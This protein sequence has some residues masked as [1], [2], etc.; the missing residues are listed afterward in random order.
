MKPWIPCA[1][2]LAVI[3]AATTVHPLVAPAPVEGFNWE[4]MT[5][6]GGF[7]LVPDA[8][9]FRISER[10][11]KL[12]YFVTK[13]PITAQGFDTGITINVIRALPRT[14]GVSPSAFA[15][16]I[17]MQIENAEAV[18][19]SWN[20]PG[21]VLVEHGVEWID[22]SQDVWVRN[23]YRLLAND[24]TGTLYQVSF[25]TPEDDRSETWPTAMSVL[26]RILFDGSI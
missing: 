20:E 25:K 5:A 26:D 19:H 4:E 6:I 13:D 3:F 8:W 12:A 22:K 9:R 10:D 7:V 15:R 23:H 21:D 17:V 11:A 2:A 14:M 16:D 18:E 1:V 24:R